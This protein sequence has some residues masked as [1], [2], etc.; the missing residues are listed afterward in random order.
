MKQTLF[1]ILITLLLV[2]TSLAQNRGIEIVPI[3]DTSGRQVGIYKGSY[4]LIFGA[5]EYVAGWPKLPSVIGE[6]NKIETALKANGFAVRRILNPDG[7]RLK[8]EFERFK[9][10]YGYSQ[11]NRLLIF[12]SGHGYSRK[13]GDKGYLVPV[14]APDPRRDE[15]GFLRKALPMSQVLAW[16]RQIEAKHAL[17]LFDSCFSGTIFKSKALPKVPPHISIATSRPVRQFITAGD[18]GEEVPAKSVFATCFLRALRGDADYSKDGYVT[19]TELG[20]YLHQQVLSYGSGQTP[21]YGKIKDPD[22]DEGDFVFQSSPS[23][24]TSG[25]ANSF[26]AAEKKRLAEERA[27]V[28]SERREFEKMKS[29]YEERKKLE[30]ERKRLEREKEKLKK[31][32]A[33]PPPVS[34]YGTSISSSSGS[35]HRSGENFTDATTGMK[36]IWVPKGCFQMG[37]NNGYSNEKPVHKV[38]VDGF[39]IGKYEVTQGQWQKVMGTNPSSFKKGNNYPVE[40]VSWNDCQEFIKKLNRR[41]GKNFRLPTEAEWE[42]AARGGR[43]DEKYSG[44][45]DVGRVAWYLEN[46]GSSTHPVGGKAAN[47]FGLYDMSGN[48]WEWCSD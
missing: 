36:M 3:K 48:V 20:M 2:T 47:G 4:A 34:T 42:Y 30:E 9:N 13:Q 31:T 38:C 5:S 27:K 16:C 44:G 28:E 21:Q 29:F 39:W 1:A 17:F 37:S 33:A 23:S 10:D 35:G 46:S 18:A 22:L 45:N 12:F 25:S 43:A 11:D 32:M 15:T 8:S 24:G 14:D 19:G 6:T 41:S 26:L 40:K 7:A